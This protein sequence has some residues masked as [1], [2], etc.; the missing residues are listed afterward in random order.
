MTEER[1]NDET[2]IRQASIPLTLPSAVAVVGCGGVGSWIGYFLAL[3]GVP[4]LYLFDS[5]KVSESNLN[6]MPF[7]PEDIGRTK[8]E[9][10]KRLILRS[11]PRTKVETMPHF[12]SGFATALHMTA[13]HETEGVTW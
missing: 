10:L 1:R 5:D 6:R 2:Y 4:K 7:G 11:R 3:A 9:A 13:P 8:P 12:A